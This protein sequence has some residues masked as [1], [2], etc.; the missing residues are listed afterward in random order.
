MK[1]FDND[2]QQPRL[3]VLSITHGHPADEVLASIRPYLNKGDI[4][5]DGGNEWYLDTER[6][7]K[8]MEELGVHFIWNGCFWWISI[9]TTRSMSFSWW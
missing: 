1:S 3:L 5:L 4:I 8:E 6:R 7:Q 9:S 2:K